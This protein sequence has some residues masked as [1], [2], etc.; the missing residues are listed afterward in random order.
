MSRSD[1]LLAPHRIGAGHVTEEVVLSE[2]EQKALE[3]LIEGLPEPGTRCPTC[4]H[5]FNKKRQSTSPKTKR[6]AGQLPVDR[7]DTFNEN[8]DTLQEYVGMDDESYPLGTLLEHM[9]A[10]CI[11]HREEFKRD[12]L[13]SRTT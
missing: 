11:Q 2:A 1:L 4:H 6:P 9:L 13:E 7:A 3:V 5:R 10:F 8:A 12:Y